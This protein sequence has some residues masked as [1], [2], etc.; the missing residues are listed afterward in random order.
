VLKGARYLTTPNEGLA[1]FVQ[2]EL[3]YLDY[4]E[5]L[6]FYAHVLPTLDTAGSALLGCN[7]RFY[8]L[9][10]L[11]GRKDA[12]H[13]WL[14]DRCREVEA[15]P[16]DHLDLWAR[17][18]Y[19]ST[20]ITF[21][22]TIQELLVDPDMTVGIFSITADIAQTFVKQIKEE[23]ERNEGLIATYPDVLWQKPLVEAPSWS[24]KGG[25]VVK[26]KTNPKEAT[27]EGHG[28]VQGMPTG[29][30]FRLRIYDDL[31]TERSVT[32][33][34]M[35]K[36]TTEAWELSDNL[37]G[38]EGRQWHIGTRYSFADTYGVL[39]ERNILR[40]RLYPATDNGKMDGKPVFISVKRWEEKKNK[41][42]GTLAAQMLQNPL[43]GTEQ[44]FRVEW[45]R[46]YEIRPKT[47][48]VYIM[49]DPSKG[50]TRSSDRT[51]I[52]VV[53]IDT[54][55]NKY[56]L[57]GFR[58]RMTMSERWA[59]LKL[60]WKKWSNEKGVQTVQVGWERYGQQTDDEY[61]AEQMDREGFSFPIEELAWTREGPQSKKDRVGRL[62]PDFRMN[63]FYLPAQVWEPGGQGASLWRID[64]AKSH[65]V[66]RK[67]DRPTNTMAA[68]MKA[69]NE[70]LIA[71]PILRKDEDGK[72]YDLTRALMEEMQF[73]PFAPKDDLV[74]AVS[75]IYDMTPTPPSIHELHSLE[76][77]GF[78]DA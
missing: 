76:D 67:L 10:G 63:R 9:T 53:G 66:T 22:G 72:L 77:E 65:I 56:L 45:L 27:V 71:K 2:E 54:A 55:G 33:P 19:K 14:F 64:T 43:A 38:G 15:A 24:L 11:L 48:N 5:T 68:A 74:D 50:K 78:P 47:L 28:L 6:R 18:H 20:I 41:Q 46:P 51:A 59:A 29:R 69:S 3:P 26:R 42:R 73:F 25:I 17:E 13:P 49:G 7:D 40:P 34:E 62:E 52:A 37:A 16:D 39:M 61:F 30:H 31:V 36:K 32:N 44:T 58:H 60:L 57:D 1:R 21:A 4:Q 12:I 35:V 8:L 70:H 23:L 75:R